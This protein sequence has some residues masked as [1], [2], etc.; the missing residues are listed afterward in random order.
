MDAKLNRQIHRDTAMAPAGRFANDQHTTNQFR[1]LIGNVRVKEL[2]GRHERRGHV[3]NVN[4]LGGHSKQLACCLS[5]NG[6]VS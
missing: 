6:Q 1:A 2:L 4:I 3:P 5:T